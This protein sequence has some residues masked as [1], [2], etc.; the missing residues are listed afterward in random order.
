MWEN[1]TLTANDII[2]HFEN[3]VQLL[4]FL[5]HKIIKKYPLRVSQDK[6]F[7]NVVYETCYDSMSKK[8]KEIIEENYPNLYS[9]SRE[10]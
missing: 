10:K 1:D 9:P 2:N 6:V 3:P 8:Q 4:D 5:E 7:F